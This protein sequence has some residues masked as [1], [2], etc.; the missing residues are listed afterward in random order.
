MV[1]SI[2]VAVAENGVIGRDNDLVW[3][4]P[5]DMA[6]FKRMTRGH[7]VIMGRRNFESIPHQYRPLPGRPNVVLSRNKSYALEGADL[8]HSLDEALELARSRGEN[9]AFVIG[10]AKVYAQALEEDVVDVIYLTTVHKEYKG[11]AFFPEIDRSRWSSEI[12][13]RKDADEKHEAAFTIER[14]ERKG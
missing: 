4:L 3:H 2:I 10:G 1:V 8:V 12:L 5:E 13:M 11:D 14:L 9:E 6:F 7:H